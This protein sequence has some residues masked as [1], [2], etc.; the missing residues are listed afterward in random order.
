MYHVKKKSVFFEHAV[1]I[2][3][4]NFLNNKNNGSVYYQQCLAFINPNCRSTHTPYRE[5]SDLF[6][7]L[8]AVERTV[9]C[10]LKMALEDISVLYFITKILEVSVQLKCPKSHNHLLGLFPAQFSPKG[11]FD[12]VCFCKFTAHILLSLQSQS[13]KPFIQFF[14]VFAVVRSEFSKK[15]VYGDLKR[16]QC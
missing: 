3:F 5:N 12:I 7:T 13:I 16:R 2:F 8:G 1:N 10:V 4:E 14:A 9:V 11:M 6:W 15:P